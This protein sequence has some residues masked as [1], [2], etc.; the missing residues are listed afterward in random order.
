MF[1]VR[2]GLPAPFQAAGIALLRLEK[3]RKT[4]SIHAKQRVCFLSVVQPRDLDRRK[5]DAKIPD[6]G[7]STKHET[8]SLVGSFC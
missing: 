7:F 3:G 8:R 2:L 1:F 4:L 5:S 6:V